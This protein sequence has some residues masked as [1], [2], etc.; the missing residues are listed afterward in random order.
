[1][2]TFTRSL[3]GGGLSI[4]AIK[5]LA[6]ALMVLDHIHQMFYF[7]GAPLWL[8]MAGRLVFP[9][10]LF[11]CVEGFAHTRSK[12]RYLSRL[13]LGSAAMPVLTTLL[14]QWISNEQVVLMNNAF[15]TFFVAGWYMLCWDILTGSGPLGKRFGKA[16]ALGLVPILC[17]LPLLAVA[18][19]STMEAVPLPLLRVLITLAL[20][21]PSPLTCEGGAAMAA[22]GMAFYIFRRH[23]AIQL[24]ALLLLSGITYIISGGY[25]W[26]MGFAAGI[27]L[28]YNGQRGN[29]SRRFFYLF[30]PGHLAILY[31][32]SCW[33]A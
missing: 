20:M 18:Q 30:Y 24:A 16:L 13:L 14:Q 27:L 1:M 26:M 7:Q 4:S 11:A 3:P 17:T 10:F 12:K 31:L 6:A 23:R 2:S 8:S 22:L 33:T 29:G 21:F 28:L 9:L 5:Y 25:Q 19:L 15:S 32:L